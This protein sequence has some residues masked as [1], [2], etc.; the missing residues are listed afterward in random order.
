MTMVIYFGGI[1]NRSLRDMFTAENPVL[2][3]KL[4]APGACGVLVRCKF[5]GRSRRPMQ[6]QKKYETS[7]AR[8]PQY[9]FADK[10]ARR[11]AGM[12]V[13]VWSANL[14]LPD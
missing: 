9:L 11:V 12:I 7:G 5:G 2:R 8:G 1:V 10:T 4:L 6:K 14:T 13:D 3:D